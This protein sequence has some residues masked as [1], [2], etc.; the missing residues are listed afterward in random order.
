MYLRSVAL[1]FAFLALPTYVTASEKPSES[2]PVAAG[3]NPG[4]VTDSVDRFTG[5]RT[6]LFKTDEAPAIRKPALNL[7]IVLGSDGSLEEAALVISVINTSRRGGWVYLQCHSVDWLADGKRVDIGESRHRGDVTRGGVIELITQQITP[8]QM[9]ALV[10]AES[11][12]YKICNDEF[13]VSSQ[14]LAGMRWAVR[15]SGI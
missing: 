9:S 13:V 2:K 12:E 6:I 11:V 10:E 14:D 1:G 4:S 8:E 15:Q 5:S 3:E 7:A